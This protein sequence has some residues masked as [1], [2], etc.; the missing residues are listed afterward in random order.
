MEYRVKKY[1]ALWFIET[2]IDDDDQT[3]ASESDDEGFPNRRE[4]LE[5]MESRQRQ[6]RRIH[7]EPMLPD[8]DFYDGGNGYAYIDWR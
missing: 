3:W 8:R 4:A 1:D 7:W 2:S 6:D 5:E